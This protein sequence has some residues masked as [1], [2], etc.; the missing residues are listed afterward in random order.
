MIEFIISSHVL[1]PSKTTTKTEGIFMNP[2]ARK[3]AGNTNFY[4]T[5]HLYSLR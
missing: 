4:T 2:T 1:F 5:T 3:H